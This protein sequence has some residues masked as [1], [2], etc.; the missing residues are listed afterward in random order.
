MKT[1]FLVSSVSS[2]IQVYI[3]PVSVY[4][5]PVMLAVCCQKLFFTFPV[6]D[7][8]HV[9]TTNVPLGCRETTIVKFYGCFWNPVQFHEAF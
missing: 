2:H 3:Q 5:Q 9:F 1:F 4:I 6:N 8:V 7:T